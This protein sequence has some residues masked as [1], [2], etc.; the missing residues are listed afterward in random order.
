MA[1]L[2]RNLSRYGTGD[3]SPSW[4]GSCE[5]EQ[6]AWSADPVA[7]GGGEEDTVYRARAVVGVVLVCIMLVCGA[8]NLLFV[9]AL[10]RYKSLRSITNLLIVNLAVSDLVVAV[11][12]CPFEMDYYVVSGLSWNFGQV[13]CSA[14]NYLRMVSLY[15][16]TNALL[17][18]A[19]DRYLVIVHPLRPRMKFR[20][21]Y[22][23]LF[24]VWAVSVVVSIPAAFFTTAT[25][26]DFDALPG[27]G[28]IF[29]G[30]V[31]PAGK[32]LYYRAYFL[33]LFLLEFVAPVATMS[34][35]YLHISR[36]LWF[37]MVPGVQT[38][39]VRQRLRARR[40]TVLVLVGVLMAYVLCWAPYYAY[41]LVRDFFPA[42]LLRE[43]HS[44]TVYY[45]VK[46]AALSNSIVNTVF[47][48][49]VKKDAVRYGRRRRQRALLHGRAQDKST[50]AMECRTTVLPVSE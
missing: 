28:K 45:A 11:V 1:D 43:R 10:A 38:S 29:C 19:V 33:S 20:T 47:F 21:A 3:A 40:K 22:C 6:Y 25:D 26:F 13:L 31:W 36:E 14:V 5:Y 32:V 16:S 44:V 27:E 18:I 4:N 48:V 24:A 50:A 17:V 35:C 46:C 23:V 34:V 49:A 7:G 39:Q 42:V 15:V 30:Q 9:A 41:G 12:C 2:C 8:G 37:K